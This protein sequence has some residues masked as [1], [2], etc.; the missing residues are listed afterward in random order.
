M[1]RTKYVVIE[2]TAEYNQIAMSPATALDL[3]NTPFSGTVVGVPKPITLTQIRRDGIRIYTDEEHTQYQRDR[4]EYEAFSALRTKYHK[5]PLKATVRWFNPNSGIGTIIIEG[6][7]DLPSF[8]IYACNIKG[9]KTWYP[10]TACVSYETGEI[11]DIELDMHTRHSIFV[12]GITPGKLD[13]AEWDRI[14]DQNL[15]FR[16]DEDGK[17][18]NGLFA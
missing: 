5:K 14:K 16:C 1:S 4:A 9:R 18:I 11:V 6:A 17:A 15:A 7:E 8:P 10:E 13:V 2:R 3:D 12:I